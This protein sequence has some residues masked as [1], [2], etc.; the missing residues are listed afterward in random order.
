MDV[1]QP[2]QPEELAD[3]V[4]DSEE[5]QAAAV[6]AQSRAI[7]SGLTTSRMSKIGTEGG[8][9]TMASSTG[10][11]PATILR[12]NSWPVMGSCF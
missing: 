6:F 4:S 11:S 5:Q 10:F 7:L 9:P 1:L 8:L 2:W 12:R 3:L